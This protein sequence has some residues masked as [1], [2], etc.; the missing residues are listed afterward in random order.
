MSLV[1]TNDPSEFWTCL[2]LPR[3]KSRHKYFVGK[4]RVKAYEVKPQKLDGV[5]PKIVAEAGKLTPVYRPDVAGDSC[6]RQS[7]FVAYPLSEVGPPHL[8]R[9]EFEG[10]LIWIKRWVAFKNGVTV[11][12]LDGS[13]RFKQISHARQ[14]F[15]YEAYKR[16]DRSLPEIAR[17][18]G[19]KDHTTVLHGIRKHSE[20]IGKPVSGSTSTRSSENQPRLSNG[21]FG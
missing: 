4:D 14:E 21:Q 11:E 18:C 9:R 13:R 19:G 5:Q 8:I 2:R 10:D 3:Q 1:E 16:T 6:T 20:R 7:R 12:D 17:R 15:F